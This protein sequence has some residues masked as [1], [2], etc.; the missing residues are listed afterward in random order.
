VTQRVHVPAAKLPV[1]W[2][3]IV[4]P[5]VRFPVTGDLVPA[6]GRVYLGGAAFR[7]KPAVGL[8]AAP[9]SD[10]RNK[11]A[12]PW[13]PHCGIDFAAR[14]HGYRRRRWCRCRPKVVPEPTLTAAATDAGLFT[15]KVPLPVSA[16][17]TAPLTLPAMVNIED[18]LCPNLTA[19]QRDRAVDFIRQPLLTE[20]PPVPIVSVPVPARI[21][22]VEVEKSIPAQVPLRASSVG[23]EP[24]TV[25]GA[26]QDGVGLPPAP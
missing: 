23:R 20:M 21:V 10:R 15:S 12:P 9:A 1:L 16:R 2:M 11:S 22:E 14:V 25:P 5:R 19:A 6:R 26:N 4:P 8:G 17:F 18:L 24:E 3:A 13:R 7:S